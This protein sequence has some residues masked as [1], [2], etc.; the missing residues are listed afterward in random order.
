[1]IVITLMMKMEMINDAVY[2]NQDVNMIMMMR[3]M[4]E[5][6]WLNLFSK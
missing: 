2:E 6:A 1:M 5:K 4:M 3:V